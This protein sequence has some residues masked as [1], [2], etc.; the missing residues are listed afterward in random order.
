MLRDHHL[1]VAGR[2]AV[3]RFGF[4][5]VIAGDAECIL[6]AGEMI[7]HAGTVKDTIHLFVTDLPLEH[8]LSG[9]GFQHF[10]ESSKR[11]DRPDGA[12]DILDLVFDPGCLI[13]TDRLRRHIDV[14]NAFDIIQ[15][16]LTDDAP[17]L[18]SAERPANQDDILQVQMSDQTC[19]ILRVGRMIHSQCRHSRTSMRSWIDRNDPVTVPECFYLPFEHI[20]RKCP[21]RNEDDRGPLSFVI[22]M[23]VDPRHSFKIVARSHGFPSYSISMLSI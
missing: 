12:A 10:A 7:W 5:S 11:L 13:S 21:S 4:L 9:I 6:H 20:C 18:I 3:S 16:D 22:I 15:A 17:C 8:D 19:D 1:S 23:D 2:A 14:E